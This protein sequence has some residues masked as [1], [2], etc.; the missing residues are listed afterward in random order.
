MWRVCYGRSVET[1]ADQGH[2]REAIPVYRRAL[3]I[4]EKTL[5]PNH[6]FIAEALSKLS[7]SLARVGDLKQALALS[8]RALAIWEQAGSVEGVDQATSLM[9]HGEILTRM[10]DLEGARRT[11]EQA[12]DMRRSS[13]GG[14]LTR[15]SPRPTWR[16]VPWRRR[17]EKRR[18]L[19]RER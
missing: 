6:P 14:P 8:Q 10:G 12:V 18:T 7:A 17:W 13:L 19:Q 1:L 5:G 4:Q 15:R 3:T 2:D 16:L 9:Q 11:Y